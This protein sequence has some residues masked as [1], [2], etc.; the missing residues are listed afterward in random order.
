MAPEVIR[1]EAMSK[2]SDIYSFGIILLPPSRRPLPAPCCRNILFNVA[3][4]LPH[5]N[6]KNKLSLPT[7][8]Q[9]ARLCMDVCTTTTHTLYYMLCIRRLTIQRKTIIQGF[10]I[11]VCVYAYTQMCVHT[12]MMCMI[13]DSLFIE[14]LWA[15]V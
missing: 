2:A 7:H 8:P 11:Y 14:M 13:S 1:G 6:P 9:C 3:T 4:I 15:I 12:H 10:Y 5:T